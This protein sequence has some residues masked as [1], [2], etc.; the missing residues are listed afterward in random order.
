MKEFPLF[1]SRKLRDK[2]KLIEHKISYEILDTCGKEKYKFPL[3]FLDIDENDSSCLTFIQSNKAAQIFGVTDEKV[4]E[5]SDFMDD[6]YYIDDSHKVWN[7]YRS[8][9]KIGRLVNM[10]YP[11]RFE[12][13]TKGSQ[14]KNDIESFINMYK[15]MTDRDYKFSLIDIVSGDKIGY[16]YNYRRYANNDMG[17]IA[18]SCMKAVNKIYY[19]IYMK[20]PESVSLVIMYSDDTKSKIKARS[21]LWKLQTPEGRFFMDRV[22]TNDYSDEQIFI[23]FAKKNNWLY[24]SSQSMGYNVPIIDPEKDENAAE[25]MD[26]YVKINPFRFRKFP[27]FDT[28]SL[29]NSGKLLLGNNYKHTP[30]R[31]MTYTDGGFQRLETVFSKYYNETINKSDAVYCQIDRDWVYRSDAVKVYN[32]NDKYAIKDSPKIVYMKFTTHNHDINKPF[33][34]SNCIWSEYLKT[35]IYHESVVHVYLNL[36]KTQVGIEHKRRL[37]HEFFEVNGEYYADFLFNKTKKI[38]LTV[39]EYINKNI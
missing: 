18:N 33:L 31:C 21:L 24:K 1:I 25:R 36:D 26:L 27:Y 5:N 30:D 17:S 4:F 37:N 2:L 38:L 7:K 3:S 28:L 10:L 8:K 19:N 14:N 22:Y 34:K 6:V 9:I 12:N 32:T 16:W 35:W 23:D 29:M 20:N 15:A 39:E 13:S 11:N